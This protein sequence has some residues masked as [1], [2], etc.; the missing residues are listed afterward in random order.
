MQWANFSVW[1]IAGGVVMGLVSALAG[2][3]DAVANRDRT[4]RRRS[5]LHSI[6]TAGALL[7]AILNGF[8]H[9]RDGWTS[10]VPTG[11]VLSAVSAVLILAAAWSGYAAAEAE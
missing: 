7:V 1:L 10:V 9:S 6:L 11:L 8:I 5:A 2:I 3:L 4:R